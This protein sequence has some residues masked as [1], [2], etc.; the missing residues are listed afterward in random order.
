MTD[1]DSDNED[2]GK[3]PW[4][5]GGV[6]VSWA[7]AV[8]VACVLWAGLLKAF[9]PNSASTATHAPGSSV[10]LSNFITV[11]VL[12]L[13]GF[14]VLAGLLTGKKHAREIWKPVAI[15]Y[16]I[17]A[18]GVDLW[19][20]LDATHDLYNAATSG[21]SSHSLNDDVHDFIIYFVIN[22]F[23]VGFAVMAVCLPPG[24]PRTPA[25]FLRHTLKWLRGTFRGQAS[26]N[27]Q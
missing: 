17:G 14:G 26:S 13:T 24:F 8:A 9:W 3:W 4:P 7:A 19:R 16:L 25:A 5:P 6:S 18:A 22:V 12:F 20:V 1:Q 21:L 23:V 2:P 15:F 10:V 11:Y 27:S